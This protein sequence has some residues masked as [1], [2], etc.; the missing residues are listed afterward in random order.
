MVSARKI[1]KI[2]SVSFS[3][4]Y[5]F[6]LNWVSYQLVSSFKARIKTNA[7]GW[8]SFVCY[9]SLPK[10]DYAAGRTVVQVTVRMK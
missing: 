1:V 6:F 8:F 2:N 4:C 3:S 5:I 10:H 9:A 7:V